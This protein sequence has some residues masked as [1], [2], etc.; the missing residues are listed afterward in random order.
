MQF[1][2]KLQAQEGSGLGLIISKRIVELFNGRFSLESSHG[3]G[4]SIHITLPAP[5]DK[6]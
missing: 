6:E 4:T 1:D 2:R 3:E 5:L